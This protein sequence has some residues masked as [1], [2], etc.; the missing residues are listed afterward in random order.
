MEHRPK[1]RI[2]GSR[3]GD[4]FD[5]YVLSAAQ[6]I[7]TPAYCGLAS[8]KFG[9]KRHRSRGC[10]RYELSV[11]DAQRP[12]EG[13]AELSSARETPNVLQVKILRWFP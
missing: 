7:G 5:V 9:A 6:E 8:A 1:R 12:S 4:K 11:L 13:K 3:V 10:G 2:S